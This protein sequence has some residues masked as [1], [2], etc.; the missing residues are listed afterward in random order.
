VVSIRDDGEV[1]VGEAAE[2]RAVVD[3]ARTAREFKRRLGDPTP[4]VLGGSPYGAEAL[5]ALVLRA[6]LAQVRQRM[7]DEPA[8]TVLTHPANWGP[9]K[10]DLARETVR[11]ADVGD[12]LL[13]TEP[14]AAA[15]HYASQGSVHDGDVVAVYDFGGGTFDASVLRCVGNGAFELLGNP[16]GLERLGGIDLDQAVFAHVQDVLGRT[17]ESGSDD[18][19]V[20]AAYARLREE[21]RTA[22]EALS[23]DTDATIPVLLPDVTSQVRITRAELE[24]MVQPRL[25]ETV[26]CLR[27]ALRSAGVEAEQVSRVLLVGGTTRIPVVGEY[28]REALGRPIAV[29][30]HPKFSVALGA[31]RYGE[32]VAGGGPTGP[33]VVAGGPSLPAPPPPAPPEPPAPAE[34]PAPPPAPPPKPP[35]PPSPEPSPAPSQPA[36]ARR[37][38]PLVALGVLALVAIIAVVV[39]VVSSGG[40]GSG[41]TTTVASSTGS[42]STAAPRLSDSTIVFSSARSGDLELWS[43]DADTGELT[44]L[45]HDPGFDGVASISR[46]REHIAYVHGP[47]PRELRVMAADGS[48]VRTIAQGLPSDSRS[49][50]SPD[51]TKIAAPSGPESNADISIYDVS[52]SAA[53]VAIVQDDVSDSDPDWSPDG[54]RIVYTRATQIW[55]VAADGS[56]A[57][58]LL[59]DDGGVADPAYSP[60]GTKIVYDGQRSVEPRLFTVLADGTQRTE[61]AHTAGRLNADPMWSPDG[62]RIVFSDYT[63]T[64]SQLLVLDVAS[65]RVAALTPADGYDAYPAWA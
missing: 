45:T 52:G 29:D 40:G 33:V 32:I 37:R 4:Y 24:R 14:Q 22:K 42:S 54:S 64:T 34:P 38:G 11:L 28:V 59:I 16:E 19:S 10:Q 36:P 26:T 62:K 43:I 6:V 39:V 56:S 35:A 31:A 53:P 25:E 50:W 15:V 1:L 41:P 58:Q 63:S 12:V 21:C 30:A 49:S 20:R 27:R 7:G 5:Q 18:P 17:I 2:R 8:T 61:L 57:P 65:G 55:V 23:S 44:Q 48:D 13:L 3:P 9:Y 51:G 46:D 60:D 47:A